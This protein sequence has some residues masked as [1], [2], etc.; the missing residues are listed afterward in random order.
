MLDLIV[1]GGTCVLPSGTVGVDIGVRNGRIATIGAPGTLAEAARKVD[2]TGKLVI[3]AASTRT[4]IA[5]CPCE[6]R[7]GPTC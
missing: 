6:H 1:S 5:R 7:G 4:S 3:P 2:A